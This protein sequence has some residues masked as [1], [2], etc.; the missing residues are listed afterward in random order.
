MSSVVH[1]AGL[2]LSA[3]S[4]AWSALANSDLL[5]GRRPASGY[6][7]ALTACALT[8]IAALVV[9]AAL[10]PALPSPSPEAAG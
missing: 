2:A 3:V 5:R 9:S 1:A 7:G 6:S 4:V 8:I 10:C